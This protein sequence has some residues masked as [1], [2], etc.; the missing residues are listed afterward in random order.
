[1]NSEFDADNG[2]RE[3]KSEAEGSSW[4]F[5]PFVQTT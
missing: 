4:P 2:S 3:K 5:S 1:M